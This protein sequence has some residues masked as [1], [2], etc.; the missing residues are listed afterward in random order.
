MKGRNTT[1]I[2]IRIPDSAYAVIKR[3]AE[4]GGMSISDWLKRVLEHQKI[5]V[6]ATDDSGHYSEKEKP[7]RKRYTR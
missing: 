1:I 5:R 2:S 3:R 6:Y 4:A 7:L